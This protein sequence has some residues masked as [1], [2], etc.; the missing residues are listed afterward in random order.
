[1]YLEL[2]YTSLKWVGARVSTQVTVWT[3]FSTNVPSNL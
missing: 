2:K 1:M 3:G